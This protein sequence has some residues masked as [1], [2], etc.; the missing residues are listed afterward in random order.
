M[1]I[2][3]CS[4]AFSENYE[5]K[6]VEAQL[7]ENI[8]QLKMLKSKLYELDERYN[9]GHKKLLNAVNVK[10]QIEIGIDETTE[11]I[12]GLNDSIQKSYSRIPSVVRMKYLSALYEDSIESSV[13]QHESTKQLVTLLSSLESQ[14]I[15]L[16]KIKDD[17]ALL[18]ARF[19]EFVHIEQELAQ[20]LEKTVQHKKEVIENLYDR[21]E[22]AEHLTKFVEQQ[23]KKEYARNNKKKTSSDYQF[24]SNYMCT[25]V[26]API[27]N[28]IEFK[29]SE[30]LKSCSIKSPW[31]GK[32][33][34][35][36]SLSNYGN[37]LIVEHQKKDGQRIRSIFLG[38][39]ESKV[40]T[41]AMVEQGE[42]IGI[43][44]LGKGLN[45]NI[46]YEL[47]NGK[48]QIHYSEY[49]N[50]ERDIN[51]DH[52]ATRLGKNDAERI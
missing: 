41:S 21:R 37:V 22:S 28:G 6:D 46:Y 29:L 52:M 51:K 24:A 34:Y 25:E 14:Q 18:N 43:A 30:K 47:R 48:N 1:S 11:R 17:Y 2:F 42:T 20:V 45:K 40:V 4:S 12:T 27:K 33:V 50:Q 23:K 32:V 35:Q 13:V 7:N 15:E 44:K 16:K 9:G 3:Y 31:N 5:I 36:G 38:E 8:G 10:R 26:W 19:E 49:M 39:I